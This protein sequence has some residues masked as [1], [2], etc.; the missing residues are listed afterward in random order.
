MLDGTPPFL[1][2]VEPALP[3][4][5][6]KIPPPQKKRID[7]KKVYLGVYEDMPFKGHWNL[8]PSSINFF[9]PGVLFSN[10][11][12]SQCENNQIISFFFPPQCSRHSPPPPLLTHTHTPHALSRLISLKKKKGLHL[13]AATGQIRGAAVVAQRPGP[14]PLLPHTQTH[15]HTHAAGVAPRPGLPLLRFTITVIFIFWHLCVL[16]LTKA[17]LY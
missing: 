12:N 11:S 4:G 6:K 5:K 1:F 16:R 2:S 3:E 14:G 13:D 7:K 10:P 17:Q 9:P 8:G 15:S